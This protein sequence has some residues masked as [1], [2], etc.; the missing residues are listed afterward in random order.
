[1]IRTTFGSQ[2]WFIIERRENAPAPTSLYVEDFIWV[3]VGV[4]GE[5]S[6]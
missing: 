2:E 5:S 3:G 6:L 4:V 1:M